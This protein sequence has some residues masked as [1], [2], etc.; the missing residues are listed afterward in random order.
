V[1]RT[2][3]RF[4]CGKNLIAQMLAGSRSSRIEKLRLNRL[5]TFGLLQDL[6]QPEIL[7]IVDG[8]ISMG[9]LEQVDLDNRRP[10]VQLTSA[11]RDVMTGKGE[12]RGELPI[13]LALVGRLQRLKLP[14][15]TQRSKPEKISG[16]SPAAM[17]SPEGPEEVARSEPGEG[18]RIAAAADVLT[19]ALTSGP[20]PARGRKEA[21]VG[22]VSRPALAPSPGNASSETGSRSM[23]G[24][25]GGPDVVGAAPPSHYWTWRLLSA[26]FAADECAS[27]RGVKREVIIDHA[28]R[29]LDCGWPV[30]VESILRPDVIAAL[31]AV[32]G[33]HDPPQIRPLLEQLPAGTTYEEVELFLKCRRQ[34]RKG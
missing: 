16:K 31:R 34:P 24:G 11:G 19:H 10:V 5:S 32:V 22:E 15:E 20:A 14:A 17:P 29:A 8:L 18:G 12:L 23:V 26:G 21:P 7:L 25:G 30:R 6:S 2:E 28:S 1:A 4:R 9:Y 3:A 13:P 27:V 33:E